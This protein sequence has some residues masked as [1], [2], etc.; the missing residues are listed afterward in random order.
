MPPRKINPGALADRQ[1]AFR[2]RMA[3]AKLRR[4]E[5][6][7]PEEAVQDAEV[8]KQHCGIERVPQLICWVLSQ[9]RRKLEDGGSSG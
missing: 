1:A 5:Y 2:E 9:Q 8:I 6:Y 4:R 3:K 7:L